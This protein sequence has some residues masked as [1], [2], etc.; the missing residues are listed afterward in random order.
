MAQGMLDDGKAE[1]GPPGVTRACLVHPVEALGETRQ[2]LGGNPLPFVL[3]HEERHLP[4]LA[5]LHCDLASR[6]GVVNGVV[7]QVGD[8]AAQLILIPA[9]EQVRLHVEY[10]LVAPLA[11]ERARLL[12]Q[13]P[14]HGGH[15]HQVGE[16]HRGGGF[17]A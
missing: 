17:D 12:L 4:L 15:V 14:Q 11:G 10:D 13:Q 16:I 6:R 1:P 9:H 5:P 7:D 3:H 2:V 8:G